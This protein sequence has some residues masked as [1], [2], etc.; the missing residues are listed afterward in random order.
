MVS[1]DR[2]RR[3]RQRD[4]NVLGAA[5]GTG[6]AVDDDADDCKDSSRSAPALRQQL[7][8]FAST[9][10]FASI[11]RECD[12]LL[13]RARAPRA[14]FFSPRADFCYIS[15]RH[16]WTCPPPRPCRPFPGAPLEAIRREGA[17][18]G[19]SFSPPGLHLRACASFRRALP[20]C[21][22]CHLCF[23]SDLAQFNSLERSRPAGT[24]R[25]LKAPWQSS[26]R[27]G[28]S[29]RRTCSL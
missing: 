7:R 8:R 23:S 27:H 9:A 4:G 25:Q 11:S 5:H 24:P 3:V 17:P 15:L 29:P 16:S 12:F 10:A 14:S 2:G 13:L 20:Q 21:H 18:T 1:A 6:Q 28:L 19:R 22:L 26:A